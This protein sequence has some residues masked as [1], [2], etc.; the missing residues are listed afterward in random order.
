MTELHE[1]KVKLS[2]NQKKNLSSAYQKRETIVLRLSKD[3]LPGN[4]TLYVPMNT[5]KRLQ[6]NRKMNKGMQVKLVK[7]NI[8][9]QVGGSLLTSIMSLAPT[10]GKTIGLSALAGLASEGA[11]QIVKSI[12]GKGVQTGGYLI[13]HSNIDKLIAHIDLLTDKQKRDIAN[14]LQIGSGVSI[15]PTKTQTG[16]I[17]GAL[18]ASIGIPLAIDAIKRLTGGGT[19]A[20]RLGK[21][22][23]PSR[24]G[25]AAPR[26]GAYQPPP[27]FGSWQDTLGRRCW[28][29]KKKG[30]KKKERKRL[31]SWEKKSIQRRSHSWSDFVKPKFHKNKPMSNHDLMRWCEYLKIPINSV[32][33]RDKT[34]PHNHKQALFIYNLEPS[35]MSGS[36]WVSTHAKDRVINYFDSFGMPPFQ[37]IVDHAIK[38]NLTLVHQ[39]NQIQALNTTTC[40]YT[41]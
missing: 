2:D 34:I 31:A 1:I 5:V 4:D 13:P 15:K 23:P 16:G 8:R 21:P 41:F 14:A 11:S 6:K 27:F 7:S 29:E 12:T 35:Y 20:P 33:S 40:V 30:K 25:G 18:L 36:H 38:N 37:E 24:K 39:N 26:L 17:L 32:L 28:G 9:K 10:I 19:A 22:P 3:S